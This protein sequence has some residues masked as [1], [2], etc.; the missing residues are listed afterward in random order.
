MVSIIVLIYDRPQLTHQTLT[1][2][3]TTLDSTSISHEVILIDNG[4]QPPT[5]KLLENYS[6]KAHIFHLHPNRGVAGGKN[7]GVRQAKGEHLYISDNDMYFLPGW[8][9]SLQRTASAFSHAKIISGFRHPFHGVIS[10]QHRG[11]I[12][13]EELHQAVGSTWFLSR[14]TWD[15]FGPLVEGLQVGKD[16]VL[17]CNQVR[18]NGYQVG[19]IKP[20]K[21]IHCGAKNTDG[22]WSPGAYDWSK[23]TQYLSRLPKNIILK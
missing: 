6:G 17:F 15:R 18:N 22:E 10:T 9:K 11:G 20:Y 12:F 4:S 5:A 13:F 21:V 2:L 23:D 3:F 19:S 16:D 1:S 14:E 8:L 7:F